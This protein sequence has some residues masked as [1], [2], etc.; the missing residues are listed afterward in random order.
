MLRRSV[1][2]L[3]HEEMRQGTL[4]T[5]NIYI[6]KMVPRTAASVCWCALFCFVLCFNS[7]FGDCTR[8]YF[9]SEEL[10]NI[11]VTTPDDLFP[12]FLLPT[13]EMLDI[14]VKG[15]HSFTHA[16]KHRRRGRRAGALVRL[17]QHGLRTPLPGMFSPTCIHCPTNWR[18][19]SYNC[20]WGTRG[21]FLHLPF[22]AS[23]RRGLVD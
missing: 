19:S 11:R 22:C 1:G 14:L 18:N 6:S 3:E 21:T 17:R 4:A 20:C 9:T 10:R 23:R 2:K 13:L 8:S 12:T 15:A 7:V 5:K 16:V